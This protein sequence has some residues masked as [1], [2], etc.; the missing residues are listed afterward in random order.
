MNQSVEIIQTEIKA[1]GGQ[2][3][4][5]QG[6]T[7][8]GTKHDIIDDDEIKANLVRNEEDESNSSDEEENQEEGI[9]FDPENEE[10]AEADDSN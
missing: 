6:P 3:K 9:D 10:I 4:L 1:R 7:R 2:Y 8:I 5:V